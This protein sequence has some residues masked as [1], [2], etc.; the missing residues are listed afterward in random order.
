MLLTVLIC[1][2]TYPGQ[3]ETNAEALVQYSFTSTEK[4][5]EGSLG[6]TAQDGQLDLTQLL[7]YATG[8]GDVLFT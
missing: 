2:L 4:K 5:P 3:A 6:R 7:N 8:F 1:Q